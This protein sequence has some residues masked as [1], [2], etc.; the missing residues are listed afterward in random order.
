M[1][2]A[3]AGCLWDFLADGHPVGVKEPAV[4]GISISGLWWM[5]TPVGCEYVITGYR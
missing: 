3:V 2:D 4:F 1:L 5:S